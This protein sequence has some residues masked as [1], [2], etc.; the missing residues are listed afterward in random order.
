MSDDQRAEIIKFV[1]SIRK[2]ATYK[3]PDIINM[4]KS[5]ALSK[6][7][8]EFNNLIQKAFYEFPSD[9]FEELVSYILATL[10]LN[11]ET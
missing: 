11:Y 4:D 8:Q 3:Q 7:E 5:T 2:A 1:E 10:V 9:D 6:A